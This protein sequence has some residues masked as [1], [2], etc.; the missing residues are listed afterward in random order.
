MIEKA[1][2][3]IVYGLAYGCMRVVFFV[4]FVS[5]VRRR[6]LFQIFVCIC[7]YEF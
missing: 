3:I 2:I 5:L 4:G 7:F 6:S 1:C